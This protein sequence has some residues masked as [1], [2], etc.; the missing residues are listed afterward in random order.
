MIDD[1][2]KGRELSASEKTNIEKIRTAIGSY[3]IKFK[4]LGIP[5]EKVPPSEYP[6]NPQR[7]LAH[8]YG[9]LDQMEEFLLEAESGNVGELRKANRWLG[10]VQAILWGTHVYT[11]EQLKDHNR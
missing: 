8:G 2:K 4:E 5:G 11:L 9:M 10:F 3:R 6:E 1:F 7:M